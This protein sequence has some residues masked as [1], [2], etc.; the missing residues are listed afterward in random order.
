MITS[1]TL[2]VFGLY[3]TSVIAKTA[4]VGGDYLVYAAY[5]ASGPCGIALAMYTH[6][7]MWSAKKP[8]K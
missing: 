6:E 5:I 4:I 8:R 2:G 1:A 3:M 7:R